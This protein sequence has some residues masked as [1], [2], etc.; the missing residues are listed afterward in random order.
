MYRRSIVVF[1]KL[2]PALLLVSALPA[3]VARAETSE[4]RRPVDFHLEIQPVLQ[5]C[6]ACHGG[7]KKNAGFS[8]LSRELLLSPTEY[9]EP[10]LVVGDSTAGTLIERITSDDPEERMPPEEPLGPDEIEAVKAWIDQGVPWPKH[11]S[12]APLQQAEEGQSPSIDHYVRQR[13]EE[14]EISPAPSADRRTLIRRLSL[15]LTGLL[16]TVVEVDSFVSDSSPDAYSALV[17]RLLASPH[18]GERWARHWLDEARYAD[19]E[20]YEKDSPKNDAFL[21]RDWVVQSLNDDMPFDQFTVKQIAGDLLPE[22]TNADLIATKFHL[23]TQYNLEGGVDA[24]E[25]RTKR[26]I[27]RM[28][29]IGAVWLATTVGC[30]QCHDHPYD[31]ISQREFYSLVAFFNNADLAADFL[32]KVP[33]EAEKHLQDRNKQIAELADLLNKQVNDKNLSN[34]VQSR[35]SKLRNFDNSNGFVRYLHERTD[36][37]RATYILQRGDF[38]RP[39]IDDGA[40]TPQAPAIWPPIQPRGEI[41]DRLDLA[42]WLTSPDNPLVARVT[43]N[44]TWMHLFGNPLVA[45][46][47][48]FGARGMTASNVELLDWLAHWFV[49]EA[50]WSRKELIRLIVNSATY[51]QSSA[52]RPELLGVDPENELL[53]RQ[54]RFRVEA[55]I[56]RDIALQT[57]DLLSRKLGGPCV[58]PPLPAIIAQQT[59]ANSNNYKVSEGESRYRRG[60]YTFFRRTAIDPNLS[61]F[62]CPDSSSSKSQRDRS[63]NALQALATLQN[64]VFHEAA[65]GFAHRLLDLSLASGLPDHAR[66]RQAY[67]VALGREPQPDEAHLLQ[68]LLQ[69]A[70][71]YYKAHSDEAAKLVGNHPAVNVA[72]P[73]NAAWVA[74]TRVILNLD[75]FFTRE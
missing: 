23:Q 47:G 44:K 27:D 5:K 25:D 42:Y 73:E 19:S 75:E 65:Q 74:T 24:E 57:S 12:Y 69:D 30:C 7:V 40:L 21:F 28:S 9:G 60:L 55:E 54:N 2:L 41:P 6:I 35:L 34:E 22:P 11:W 36:N 56:L 45:T 61:T 48:D 18:F 49:H 46:P 15:D 31:S 66:I 17:D 59:Y 1:R 32:D 68:S 26:I 33:E 14:L 3:W 16:P 58:F 63:N 38:L 39:R 67:L 8:V 20:G 52:V 13:L 29:T 70:R 72:A 10:A 43:V 50:K 37:R 71:N 62:D 4:T 64:E 51:Q 53:A